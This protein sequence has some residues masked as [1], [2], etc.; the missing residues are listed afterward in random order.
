MK[1]GKQRVKFCD[2]HR[3]KSDKCCPGINERNGQLPKA[4]S[5]SPVEGAV[6]VAQ[7]DD[8][9]KLKSQLAPLMFKPKALSAKAVADL[10]LEAAELRSFP[11]DLQGPM[12]ADS[13]PLA[14]SKPEGDFLAHKGRKTPRAGPQAGIVAPSG[15]TLMVLDARTEL[16]STRG[17]RHTFLGAGCAPPQGLCDVSTSAAHDP[18][19]ALRTHLRVGPGHATVSRNGA[20]DVEAREQ[21]GQERTEASTKLDPEKLPSNFNLGSR[22][23][24][25]TTTDPV[26][27]GC[28]ETSA[29]AGGCVETSAVAAPTAGDISVPS[30]K[31][32]FVVSSREHPGC[33]SQMIDGSSIVVNPESESC[34]VVFKPESQVAVVDAVSKSK[35]NKIRARKQPKVR[36]TDAPAS[37]PEGTVGLLA[38]EV[39]R[40]KSV[41]AP[42][43]SGRKVDLQKVEDVPVVVDALEAK[44][45]QSASVASETLSDASQAAFESCGQKTWTNIYFRWRRKQLS[46]LELDSVDNDDTGSFFVPRLGET[47]NIVKWISDD[48]PRPSVEEFRKWRDV[49]TGRG[50]Q[51]D[52]V[53][54]SPVDSSEI[55]NLRSFGVFLRDLG[56]SHEVARSVMAA[57]G[58]EDVAGT[59]LDAVVDEA[60]EQTAKTKDSDV[61][62]TTNLMDQ[63]ITHEA[64][65]AEEI[66][67]EVALDSGC[68]EHV[69]DDL[70]IPGYLVEPSEGS[71]RNANFIVGNGSKVP[72]RGQV[73]LTLEFTDEKQEVNALTSTFQIAKITRPLMSVS[74]VCDSGLTAE[75]NKERAVVRDGNGRTV[76]I[77]KRVGGLYV[78]KMKLKPPKTPFQ[79]P[80]P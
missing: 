66:E 27:G 30:G 51:F 76:C 65:V 11:A 63:E 8:R 80:A 68:V 36:R 57:I 47:Y 3:C 69:C 23:E 43:V 21:R 48:G 2:D 52:N 72:N 5:A 74:K 13:T 34:G 4:L 56:C 37:V 16:A 6:V 28:V 50:F 29:V 24:R 67:F 71:R 79:R 18:A 42:T 40:P 38:P 54:Q 49:V 26:A 45:S 9:G 1:A 55:S 70:D 60:I 22:V 64:L 73:H 59:D 7:G 32:D 33:A 78:C 39:K 25:T 31:R 15:E 41:D 19:R 35:A 75:F 20:S 14:L 10:F 12:C 17:P 61:S 77:F 58:I 53:S 46:D 44:Q 62:F